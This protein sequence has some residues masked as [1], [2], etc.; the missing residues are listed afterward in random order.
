MLTSIATASYSIAAVAYFVLAILLLT[1]WRGRLHGIVLPVACLLSALWASLL[2]SRAT[3]DLALSLLTDMLEILR[4]AGW[5]A[6]LITLLGLYRQEDSPFPKMNPAMAAIVALYTGC[7]IAAFYSH[8]NFDFS[9]HETIDFINNIVGSLVMAILGMILVE[10]LYR[11]TPVKQR[12]GIKFACL[13]IGGIFA[14][15][16]YL[17]SD[18][19]LLRQVNP[20]IW[21][22]R[23]IVNALVVPLIAVSAARNPQWSVGITVSRRILFYSV[24]LFG[25]AAYLLAMAAAGY[26]LRFFGGGWGTVMQVSFLFGAVILLLVV[27]FSGTLRSWLRVFISKHFFSYNYD[28]REEWLHFTRTL[29][30]GEHRL[31]E[32]V[33]QALAQLVESPGGGL[34]ICRESGNCEPVTHW[35]MPSAGGLE[36]LDSPF[37]LFL[38]N[39]EWVIDLQEYA[40]NPEKYSAIMLPQWLPRIYRAW[41]VV[42]LIQHRKLFGFVV[43]AQPRSSVKLNWEVSDLLKVAGNQ[44][45]S[46]LAQHEAANALMVARQ[47]ESFNRMSTFVV[48][49]LKNLV[50]QLSLLLSNA[51]KHKTNPEFQRDM[52]ETVYLSVQ[53]MKRLLE[54]LSSSDSPDKA[55]P[56]VI[57]RLL[58][59]AVK[60]KSVAE[61]KPILE[62]Q[63]SSIAVCA[64]SSRLE[65]VLGHLIQNAIEATS[66]NG[67]VRVRLKREQDFAIVE[68]KD[69]GHGMSEEFIREKL[70]KPFES[71]KSAGMGIGVFESREYVS[72]LGG[73]LEVSSSESNGTVFRI[74]LPLHQTDQVFKAVT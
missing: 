27:L 10:Q 49:D 71:T 29:S 48:H 19:L 63:D 35:N 51:E 42:P 32:R 7:I 54:K 64:N 18:A 8:G 57:A 70:F 36:P 11:N 60:S 56:L 58:Q 37:C 43:L 31:G 45:A 40:A 13:G 5:S 47:F 16:F 12:W 25:A 46:Y 24:A 61:P 62:I 52:I 4:N 1:S 73:K 74:V 38:E 69:T 53:K 15:D 23:G 6:F 26:Y 17:Y 22:A 68:I 33:I 3:H 28:Y 34:W 14:Y 59:E 9:S 55:V 50:S 21:A 20:E 67:Q 65:R 41:L 39:R 66:R 44:A 30:E 72:E 2:A